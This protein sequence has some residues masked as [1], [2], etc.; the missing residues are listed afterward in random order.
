MEK[1]NRDLIF[2]YGLNIAEFH[3]LSVLNREGNF[4]RQ[5][6]AKHTFNYYESARPNSACTI[7]EYDEAIQSCLEK[8]IIKEITDD[9][10]RRDIERWMHDENQFCDESVYNKGDLDFTEKGAKLFGEIEE[11]LLDSNQIHPSRFDGI[12]GYKWKNK[13]VV[14]IFTKKRKDIVKEIENIRNDPSYLFGYGERLIQIG[15]PY[16]IKNWWITRFDQLD[17]GWRVDI[18][19]KEKDIL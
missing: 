7:Y 17:E 19:Y 3:I 8:G 16:L 11:R 10:C 2:G 13:N 18:I 4:R 9:D 1:L 14:S 15:E 12:V 5:Y 6:L